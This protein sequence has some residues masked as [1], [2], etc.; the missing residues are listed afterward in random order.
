MRRY[1]FATILLLFAACT[2]EATP[3]PVNMPGTP[4][5]TPPPTIP[6]PIRYALAANTEGFLADM[7]MITGSAQVEQ[8]A[9]SGNDAGLGVQ[10]DIVAAY[11]D[12]P[13][14]TRP[15]V[16]PHVSLVINTA[17]TPLDNPLLANVVRRCIDPQAVID[18]LAIPGTVADVVETSTPHILRT[19]L[20]N[21][22]WPDGFELS[23]AYAYTPGIFVI[24]DQLEASG[25]ENHPLLM[26]NEDI[27]AALD[28][29]R[30]HL[31]L[32]AWTTPD[33]REAWVTQVSDT[34]VIDLYIM[35]VSYRALPEFNITFTPGGWP[36]A[37]R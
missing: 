4:T 27:H 23:I 5:A 6:P 17:L 33:E 15:A 21:L 3:F 20:A 19:E 24:A 32:V 34:N 9:D 8:L 11:G 13:G 22:G 10:Y 25:I 7:D 36:V 12:W 30:L 35:P 29:G 16:T 28:S 1:L 31:A 37:A 2:P 14:W 26:S 18:V